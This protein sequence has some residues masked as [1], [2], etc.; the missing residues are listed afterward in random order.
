M[1]EY[2]GSIDFEYSGGKETAKKIVACINEIN[3]AKLLGDIR[4]VLT[5]DSGTWISFA[6]YAKSLNDLKEQLSAIDD[7]VNSDVDGIEGG[8]S[9]APS[10]A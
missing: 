7:Y 10:D 4:I 3:K 2:K 9:N 1:K 6:V 8:G 5:N